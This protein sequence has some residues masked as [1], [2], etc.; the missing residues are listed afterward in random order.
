MNKGAVFVVSAP[1]GAGKTTLCRMIT[2]R[3][4]RIEHSISYTTRAPRPGEVD[5]KDYYF[6]TKDN[7]IKMVEAGEFLEWAEVHG[8]LYGT[9]KNRL[10]ERVNRGIDVILDIDTQGARQIRK[11]GIDATFVFIL[12]PSMEVLKKRLISRGSDTE[13]VIKRRLKNAIKEIADYKQYDYVIINDKL[14]TAFEELKAVVL[15]RRVSIS[16]IDHRWIEE[17]FLNTRS[18]VQGAGDSF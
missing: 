11:Q 14:E 18:R 7:F 12:P 15:S 6:V 10:M 4:Q 16:N 8:N 2:D 1:S 3:L 9:S 5:G 17:H 13:D